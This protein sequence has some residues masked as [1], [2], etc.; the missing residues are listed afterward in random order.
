MQGD[1][2]GEARMD[3]AGLCSAAQADSVGPEQVVGGRGSAHSAKKGQLQHQAA[4]G[5]VVAGL[6]E[7]VQ[8]DP[9]IQQVRQPRKSQP[10]SYMTGA[11]VQSWFPNSNHTIFA[12]HMEPTQRSSGYSDCTPLAGTTHLTSL[13]FIRTNLTAVT[14]AWQLVCCLVC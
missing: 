9:G 10:E 13:T 12:G 11:A 6:T 14:P 4:C 3:L 1:Q 2:S 7:L 8:E 5:E